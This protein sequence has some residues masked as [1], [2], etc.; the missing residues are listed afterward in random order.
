MPLHQSS[1]VP[2]PHP[3]LIPS[4]KLLTH[5]F[6]PLAVALLIRVLPLPQYDVIVIDD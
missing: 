2:L 5:P 3:L 1:L 4:G 6:V